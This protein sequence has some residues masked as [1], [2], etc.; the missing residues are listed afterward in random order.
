MKANS[1]MLHFMEG[2]AYTIGRDGHIRID[3]TSLSRGHA[4]LKF[5]AGKILLRDLG[6]TNGTY[7]MVN[8]KPIKID[9][10]YV[11]PNQRV[12]LGNGH[13]K[14][15]E[16]LARAGIYTSYSERTGLVVKLASPVAKKL[17]EIAE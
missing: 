1:V 4:E 14:I 9:Q 13:Y 3:D 6:S 12:V 7:L 16:L 15:K 10:T 17:G 11:N 2:R 5:T 8:N